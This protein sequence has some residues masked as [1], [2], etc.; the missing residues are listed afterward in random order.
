MFLAL[1]ELRRSKVRFGLLI[2]SVGLL[3]FLI[4]FQQAIQ[5]G[6]IT[7]F[8]GAIRNQSAPVIVYSIDGRRNLQ[9]SIIPPNLEK[10][11]RGTEGVDRAGQLGQGTFT[12]NTSSGTVSIAIIGYGDEELGRPS[13]LAGG[14]FPNAPNEV[15]AIS[16]A[17]EDGFGIGDTFTVLPNGRP[18]TVVGTA[19]EIG[20]QAS[21]TVFTD[22][23]TYEAAVRAANP[24][25][26]T[27]LPNAIVVSPARG[28]TA[29]ELAARINRSADDADALTR[30]DAAAKTPGVSSVQS[31]FR[32]IFVLF[33]LVV[34]LVTGLFFLIITLQKA[35]ALTLLRAI[36]APAGR[37]VQSLVIQVLIVMGLGIL[38]GLGLYVP[39]ANQNLGGIQLRFSAAAVAAWCL[40]LLILG[41]LSSLASARRV[42][43]IDPIEA[44]TGAGVS[45]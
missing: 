10:Q 31:S 4:L 6:L 16:S 26:R 19:D 14:R 15:V 40:A 45:V 12:V 38:V 1:N 2:T 11:I 35:N 24:D 36:G 30:D 25:A 5:T 9:G 17:A 29:D 33:G 28:V 8:I 32:L 13:E 27:V 39:V 42:L 7:S 37:L 23:T 41:V 20:Y 44:T 21:T 34:P 3:V 43:R 22:F 18:L